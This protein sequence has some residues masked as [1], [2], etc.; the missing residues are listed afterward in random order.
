[1]SVSGPAVDPLTTH[2]VRMYM[3]NYEYIGDLGSGS[4]GF[5][6]KCAQRATGRVVA[7]KGFKLAHTDKKVRDCVPQG[8][9]TFQHMLQDSKHGTGSAA[10]NCPRFE[11][12]TRKPCCLAH[13]VRASAAGNAALS[14]CEL[15]PETVERHTCST[16]DSVAASSTGAIH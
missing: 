9:A 13:L 8:H 14:T 7:V 2:S 15:R 5:V 6:W 3:Q 12:V 16:T 4:Y 11:H 1:M 10:S